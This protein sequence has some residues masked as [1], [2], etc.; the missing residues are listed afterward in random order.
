MDIGG[1][2]CRQPVVVFRR[3]AS[4]VIIGCRFL[5][6]HVESPDDGYGGLK[7]YG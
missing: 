5:D 7:T 1:Y 2:A 6:N 4:D 3:F